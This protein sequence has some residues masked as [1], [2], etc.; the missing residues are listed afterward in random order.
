MHHL[1]EALE[2]AVIAEYEAGKKNVVEI[3]NEYGIAVGTLH[4]VIERNDVRHRHAT[5]TP[6]ERVEM[7]RLYEKE[8]WSS[9]RIADHM[10]VSSKAVLN[11]LHDKGV[12]VEPGAR[13]RCMSPEVEREFVELVK[14]VGMKL[15]SKKFNITI[16]GGYKIAARVGGWKPAKRGGGR[17]ST[18]KDG[19]L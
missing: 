11:S 3:A 4:R 8:R 2:R 7:K 13:H 9:G 5:I 1:S 10:G 14:S 12:N 15:A 17:R 16:Q 6:Q 18:L 19:A